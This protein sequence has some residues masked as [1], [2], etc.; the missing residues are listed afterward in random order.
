MF[1]IIM[2]LVV[3]MLPIKKNETLETTNP[4][5]FIWFTIL[6]ISKIQTFLDEVFLKKKTFYNIF[7]IIQ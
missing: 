2:T 5:F 3:Y 7:Q 1:T 6:S 4:N